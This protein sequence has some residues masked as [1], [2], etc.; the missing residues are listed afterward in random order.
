M[1]IYEQNGNV[2]P[3]SRELVECGFDGRVLRFGVDNEIVLLRGGRVC[4]MLYIILDEHMVEVEWQRRQDTRLRLRAGCLSL[5]PR[6]SVRW[7]VIVR[8]LRVRYT[9]SPMTARNSR[10]LYA[11]VGRAMMVNS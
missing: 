6:R 2:L 8:P 3:L 7:N 9:S 5:S 11:E 4:H 1:L 10:S